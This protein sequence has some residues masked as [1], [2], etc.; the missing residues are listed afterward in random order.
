MPPP[1]SMHT[2]NVTIIKKK[3]SQIKKLF[4]NLKS[5]QKF[6][7][8]VETNPLIYNTLYFDQFPRLA[9]RSNIFRFSANNLKTNPKFEKKI[10]Y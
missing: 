6:V 8:H 2:H 9:I 3:C 1:P 10:F 5:F 4:R 7:E